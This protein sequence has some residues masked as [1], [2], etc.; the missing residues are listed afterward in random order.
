[1]ILRPT[2]GWQTITA[3]LA[4][5]LFLITAQAA[6][7]N[8]APAGEDETPTVVAAPDAQAPVASSALALHR[9]VR[10][11]EVRE[12]LI[13]TVTDERQVATISVGYAPHRRVEAL[14]EGERL[15]AEAEAAGIAARLIAIPNRKDE[16]AISVDYLRMPSAGTS[17]AP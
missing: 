17:L 14:A 5:I 15:M 9:P 10:G 3:D 16:V 13:A 4:L 2:S 7:T 8:A 12:W 1:M 11:E 6:G